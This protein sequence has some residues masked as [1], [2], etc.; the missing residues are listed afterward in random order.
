MFNKKLM[1]LMIF[2]IALFSISAISAADNATSDVVSVDGATEDV[3]D[4]NV[5]EN[6][7]MEIGEINVSSEDVVSSSVEED[8]SLAFN[9]NEDVLDASP[10]YNS[11]SVSVSD[12]T[13]TYG[14]SGSIKM[15]ITSASS[16]YSYRYDFYLKVYDSSDS[17]KINKRYYSTISASS[18]TYSVSGTALNPGKYTIKII[19][20][21]DSKVMD[22]AILTVNS[23]PYSAY[24]VSV[25]DVSIDYHSSGSIKMT[26][27]SASSS[28][29]YKYDFYLKVYDSDNKEKIS[30]RYYSTSS[31]SSQTYSVGSTTLTPGIYTIK[32]LNN[33]DNHVM[34]T[35]K[36]NIKSVPYSSYS[37]KV[38]DTSMAYGTTG[39]IKMTITP[40]STSY[41]YY[42]YDFYLKVYDSSNRVKISKRYYST[43]SAYSETY[44]VGGTTLALGVYT[45]KIVNSADNRVMSTAKLNVRSKTYYD[46]YSVNVQ[47]ILLTYGFDGKIYMSISPASTPNYDY[48][49]DF[50]LKVYDSSNA[51][52]INQRYYSTSSASSKTYSLGATTLSP[53]SY[54]IK[55][56]NT[57][58]SK[59]MDTAILTVK[60]VFI[61][62]QD[63]RGYSDG[64]I[65][66]KARIFEDDNAVSGANLILACNGKRY[67]LM[68]DDNG[69]ADL[70]L[71]LK[72]GNY[73]VTIEYGKNYKYNTIV[74]NKRYVADKYKNV[75]VKATNAFY[76]QNAKVI[77]SFEGNLNGYFKIYKGNSLIYSKKINTNGYID[78]YFKYKS[79][80]YSFAINKLNVGKYSAQITN[81]NGK[82]L[83]KS[84]FTIKKSPT[85]TT[86]HSILRK[87]GSKKS[88]KV[89]IRDKFSSRKNV[90]GT[91]K[92]KIKG[93]T[94]KVKVKNGV[95]VVKKVKFPFKVKTYNCRVK[96]SGDKNHK[97]SSAKFKIKVKKYVSLIGAYSQVGKVGS[98][99][100]VYAGVAVKNFNGDILRANGGKVKFLIDGK[101]YIAKV[102]NGVAKVKITAPSNA[103]IYNCKAIYLGTKSIK[104]SYEMFKMMVK[105]PPSKYKVITTYAGWNWIYKYSGD[106]T[107][108]TKVWDMTA[109]F[110][111]PYKYIDTTLYKN[112]RQVYNSEYKVKYKIDGGW[113]GWSDYGTTSTAHH[114]YMVP[115]GASVD[116]I[117]VKVRKNVNSF[118]GY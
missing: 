22:T 65:K 86:S 3:V 103:K 30:Q 6:N 108:A 38:S 99:H 24:S 74:V 93:K 116:Q 57:A 26:I 8:D 33:V 117:K 63:V 17:L 77:Y 72:S 25:S 11:Y 14:K 37:V 9:E 84:S 110:R 81:A 80:S 40:A 71:H 46:A 97:A 69:Y 32:I 76:N 83:A 12:T 19:N 42:R 78:D 75:K 53:G 109:G 113:T 98:K 39:S 59:V 35:A 60:E 89:Y 48:A 10:P 62:T 64:I 4:L 34:A 68:T 66:F 101:T 51:V 91:A 18:Q 36:L 7:D 54:N 45:I 16:S 114:R 73:P 90:M 20:C 29:Y 92:F 31:S 58:D 107:V 105:K 21:H 115:D 55:I 82:V 106:F 79:H 85:K 47:D 49:Y 44:S 50:Y 27:S 67:S 100:Y 70:D 43:S 5:N 118:I 102:R 1:I 88:I 95:A 61:E 96:Y 87:V 15:T 13:M 94:Y 41:Y 104:G 56:V 2:F 23:V 28:Y 111:A 112:G 52:K